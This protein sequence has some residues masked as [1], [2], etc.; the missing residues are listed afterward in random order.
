MILCLIGVIKIN[1][2]GSSR[3]VSGIVMTLVFLIFLA[4]GVK[5]L[6]DARKL[7]AMADKEDDDTKKIR[8]WFHE[9]YDREKI[10][11]AVFWSGEEDRG[12]EE[13]YFKRYQY[14]KSVI[15]ERYEMID[16][17]FAEKLIED[18]YSEL[19]EDK[20]DALS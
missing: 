16:P 7:S 19:Y 9:T 18:L 11:R 5:T 13:D 1:V 4:I 3:I 15:C 2:T 14:I 20:G 6:D 10:D 17:D 8:D 12:I